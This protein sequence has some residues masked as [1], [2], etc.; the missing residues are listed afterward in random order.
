MR[1]VSKMAAIL[2]LCTS[3]LLSRYSATHQKGFVFV[4]ETSLCQAWSSLSGFPVNHI[5]NGIS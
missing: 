4:H 5:S 2:I 1:G 3:H